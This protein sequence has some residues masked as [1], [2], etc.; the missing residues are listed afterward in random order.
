VN[1]RYRSIRAE[2]CRFRCF[3]N[4]CKSLPF[5]DSAQIEEIAHKIVRPNRV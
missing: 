3:G 1:R 4:K 5:R 2:S